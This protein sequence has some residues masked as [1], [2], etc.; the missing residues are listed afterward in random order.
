MTETDSRDGLSREDA[1][2][3]VGRHEATVIRFSGPDREILTWPDV[4]R[5]LRTD[6]AFMATWT[7]AWKRGFDYQWKPIPI[8]P[9]TLD[10]PFFVVLIPASFPGANPIA[11]A[12]QLDAMGPDEHV[13]SFPSLGGDSTMVVPA[14]RGPYAHL[15][16]YA[17]T[18]SDAEQQDFWGEV[19]RLAAAAIDRRAATW[20]NTHG[21]AVPWLHLRFDPNHKYA[22]F[23]PYG[24]IT[25]SSQAEWERDIYAPAFGG[26]GGEHRAGTDA[27][28]PEGA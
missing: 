15:A 24:G 23:P 11:F 9:S 18:A 8:H 14:R 13:A 17:R 12:R 5:L 22:A 2:A 28:A 25:E 27:P 4:A 19:G 3:K 16:A 10:R 21:H 26:D 20:C 7:A 1:V 6:L